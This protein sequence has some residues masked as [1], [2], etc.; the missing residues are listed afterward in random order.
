M[1]AALG[2]GRLCFVGTFR[3]TRGGSYNKV[4]VHIF[5]SLSGAFIYNSLMFSPC[6]SMSSQ[7][8]NA[9]WDSRSV[10]PCHGKGLQS[11]TIDG[12]SPTEFTLHQLVSPP[13]PR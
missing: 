5:S 6:F 10:I 12:C 11:G 9:L 2:Q 3:E 4:N 8:W 13:S 7:L 1:S